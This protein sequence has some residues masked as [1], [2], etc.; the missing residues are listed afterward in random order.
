MQQKQC[1]SPTQSPSERKYASCFVGNTLTRREA[2]ELYR[3]YDVNSPRPRKR[4]IAFLA[5]FGGIVKFENFK[6]M[7]HRHKFSGIKKGAKISYHRHY[8]Y[9]RV[10]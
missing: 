9:T 6:S 4:T 8:S 7:Q 2:I 1:F 3:S 5:S 10:S